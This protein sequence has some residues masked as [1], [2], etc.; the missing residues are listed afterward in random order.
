MTDSPRA[1]ATPHLCDLP[2]IERYQINSLVI[3]G[4][5]HCRQR[6]VRRPHKWTEL[7]WHHLSTRWRY[8]VALSTKGR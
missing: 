2:E 7:R 3:C 8:G 1:T 5:P 6:W 4:Y